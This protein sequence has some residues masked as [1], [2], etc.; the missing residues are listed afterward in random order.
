MTN[1]SRLKGIAC[2]LLSALGFALMNLSIPLSGD[3][4]TVQKMFFRNLVAIGIALFTLWESKKKT[5]HTKIKNVPWCILFLR[6][7]LGTL[8]MGLNFYTLDRLLLADA[9]VLNKLAPFATLIFSAIFL[10]EK[11]ARPH[12]YALALAFLGVLLISKPTGAAASLFPYLTGV[13]GGL[14]AGGAY[15]TVRYLNQLGVEPSLT[16]LFFSAF[17]CLACVPFMLFTYTPMPLRS[18]LMLLG[19]GLAASVGQFGVTYAYRFAPASEISIFDYSSI[20]FSGLLGF[21]FLQQV[22]DGGSF[23][24]YLFIFLGAVL[25]FLYNRRQARRARQEEV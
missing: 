4:P 17:S 2:I 15:T 16:V 3:L 20:I 6:S 5:P 23:L 7:I 10:K 8:G 14:C 22:P 24:G 12:L 19:T 21:I 9:S 11:M 25:T 18:L 13:V 1:Y